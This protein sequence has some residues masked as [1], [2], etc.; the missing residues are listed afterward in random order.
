MKTALAVAA[1][2]GLIIVMP[3]TAG[4]AHPQ[5]AKIV[6]LTHEVEVLRH[7]LHNMTASRDQKRAAL[8]SEQAKTAALTTQ[9]SA[10]SAQLTERTNERDAARQQAASLQ[11]Q[12]AAIPTPLAVALE[13]VRREITWAG[14]A[15]PLS[16]QL[17]A[18]AA[19]DYTV[20]HVSVGA[21]GY[22][23]SYDGL[24]AA[25]PWGNIN[26][27]LAQQAGICPHAARVFA[28]IV[29]HFGFPVRDV[30]FA[31][32]DWNGSKGGHTAAEVYYDGGWHFFDPTFGVFYTDTA[33]HV[34]SI[35]DARSGGAIMQKD[36]AA[37][38][39]LIEDAAWQGGNDVAFELD[40][41]TTL[42]FDTGS[43]LDG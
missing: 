9:L 2:L 8:V 27:I 19:L 32:T 14:G 42:A 7:R 22:M 38:T 37:F 31:Y 39:N 24:V 4:S 30:E 33:G 15:S 23:E 43:L 35:T 3:A 13:Q 25:P 28:T 1:L 41:S 18:Q 5:R 36:A 6:R 40:P 17:V 11:T 10:I 20:G 12:L 16:G 21:Y 26:Q 34:L 29:A